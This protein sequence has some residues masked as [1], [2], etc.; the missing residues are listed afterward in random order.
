[1]PALVFVGLL[2]PKIDAGTLWH[3]DELLTANRAREMVVRGDPGTL[4]LNFT[5][6]FRKPPLQILAVRR[7]PL[8]A[9]PG[10]PELA[11]R[12]PSLLGGAACLLAL[13]WLARAAY[14]DDDAGHRTRGAPMLAL[15]G[16]GYFVLMSRLGLARHRRSTVVDGGARRRMPARANRPAL[17]V[18]HGRRLRARCVAESALRVRGVGG[19]ADRARGAR[20]AIRRTATP[21]ARGVAGLIWSARCSPRCC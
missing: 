15:M 16:C 2:W 4:T 18:D 20:A 5:P 21:P 12:L 13:A 9:L 14:P 1:M 10:R 17:V 6:D 3:H 7:S 11:V 19:R 8:R